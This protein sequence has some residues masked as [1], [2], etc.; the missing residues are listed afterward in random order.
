MLH[1]SSS[2][3]CFDRDLALRARNSELGG[4]G[5]PLVDALIQEAREPAFAGSVAQLGSIGEILAR[6]LV[7]YED[8]GGKAQTRVMT[9]QRS[10][11]GLP[12]PVASIDWLA[13][14]ETPGERGRLA[15]V[16]IKQAFDDALGQ[17]L[18]EWQ[19]DRTKRARVRTTLIG[20]HVA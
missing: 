11:N 15:H 8:E 2:A 14:D 17:H 4:L 16:E 1:M 12:E 9:F 18:I 5:H 7:H 19:P 20:L 6:Y 10:G 3:V 13:R